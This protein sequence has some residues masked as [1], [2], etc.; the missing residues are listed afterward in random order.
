METF[1]SPSELEKEGF[2][3]YEYFGQ[4]MLFLSSKE[5]ITLFPLT[6]TLWSISLKLYCSDYIIF[7]DLYFPAG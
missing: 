1:H 6:I 4:W 5:M 3:C 2:V 7:I